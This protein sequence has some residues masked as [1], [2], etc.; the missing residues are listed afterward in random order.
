MQTRV[1]SEQYKH[2]DSCNLFNPHHTIP[3]SVSDVVDDLRTMEGMNAVAGGCNTCTAHVLDEGVYFVAQH[4]EPDT[5]YFGYT[6]EKAAYTL[7]GLCEQHG[8]EYD[9]NGNT[10]KKVA[11]GTSDAY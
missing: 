3:E 1:S 11:V 5:V 10:S 4:G 2:E 6:S 9:W 7:T 8:I